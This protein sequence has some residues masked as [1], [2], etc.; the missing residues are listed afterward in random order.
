MGASA[1][2]C[3][4]GSTAHK[5]VHLPAVY[6]RLFAA[7]DGMPLCGVTG[8]SRSFSLGWKAETG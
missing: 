7:K 4:R 5:S 1:P 2:A 6:S 8:S 3:G